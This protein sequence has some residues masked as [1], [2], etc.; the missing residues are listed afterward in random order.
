MSTSEDAEKKES[1]KEFYE[2]ISDNSDDEVWREDEPLNDVEQSIADAL[3][4]FGAVDRA[5]AIMDIMSHDDEVF[6]IIVSRIT[7]ELRNHYEFMCIKEKGRK[8][9]KSDI[10]RAMGAQ[11][12]RLAVKFVKKY[13]PEEYRRREVQKLQLEL[14]AA[15]KGR[16]E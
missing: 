4:P 5:H 7:W 8:P 13:F 16:K 11:L 12:D 14:K 1:I 6:S 15:K 9:S 3:E 10:D 2:S